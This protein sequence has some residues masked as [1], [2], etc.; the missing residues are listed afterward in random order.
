MGNS[1][2]GLVRKSESTVFVMHKPGLEPGQRVEITTPDGDFWATIPE[3]SV[4]GKHFNVKIERKQVAR[5][6]FPF[7]IS[8]QEGGKL[9]RRVEL[10]AASGVE[11]EQARH[12]RAIPP[13]RPLPRH[14]PD[15]RL[16]Q[17]APVDCGAGGGG[18][19]R[20]ELPAVSG[21]RQRPVRL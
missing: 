8:F 1:L 7:A 19:S 10:E 20:R 14:N 5:E 9:R 16:A 3:H 15:T 11:R 6:S 4:V 18:S 13:C 21:C 17:S 12:A 2:H